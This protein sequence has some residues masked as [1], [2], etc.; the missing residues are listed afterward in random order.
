MKVLLL[1]SGYPGNINSVKDTSNLNYNQVNFDPF[2]KGF[3]YLNNLLSHHQTKV[4][5]SIWDDIGKKEV[6]DLY[7]PQVIK[8]YDQKE[9]QNTESTSRLLRETS[10]TYQKK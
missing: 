2:Y 5:C 9:F 6:I 7:K 1:L 10:A 8:S 4:I 3:R